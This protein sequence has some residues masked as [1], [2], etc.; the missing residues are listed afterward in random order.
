MYF[1]IICIM[2]FYMFVFLAAELTGISQAI[3]LLG[4]G[5]NLTITALIVAGFTVAYTAYGGMKASLFTDRIQFFAI[6]P[7]LLIV[8]IAGFWIGDITDSIKSVNEI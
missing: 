4:E 8:I 7:L 3:N 1:L 2:I 5:V 6:L